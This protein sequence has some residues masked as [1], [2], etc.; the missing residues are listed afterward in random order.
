MIRQSVAGES[1]EM[2]LKF[3]YELELIEKPV[4]ITRLA[5]HM[6]VSSPATVEMVKRL[7]EEGSIKHI[8]YKGVLLTKKGQ[9]LALGIIR[10][11]RLWERFL[12]DQLGL[13]WEEVHDFACKMEHTTAPEVENALDKFLG[14]PKV[15]PHGN[16]IPDSEGKV[17]EIKTVSLNALKIGQTAILV[18]VAYEETVLLE[19]LAKHKLLPGIILTLEEVA[20]FQGPLTIRIED[21]TKTIGQEIASRIFVEVQK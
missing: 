7:S 15:C 11:H 13:A 19:Y 5:Q 6:N 17:A 4:T 20:P 1:V 21:H 2:Y 18:D 3:I 14:Y 8:P 10:R 16:P 9:K 12:T